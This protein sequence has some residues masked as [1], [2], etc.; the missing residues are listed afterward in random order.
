MRKTVL[1]IGGLGYLGGRIA[2]SLLTINK[3]KVILGTRGNQAGLSRKLAGC[4]IA[5][6]NLLE[7]N[8]IQK[9]LKGVDIIIHLAA[10]NANEC[11][12]NPSNA[13]LVNAL[14]TLNLIQSAK[15]SNVKRIIYFSTAH[16]YGSYLSGDISEESLP[17]PNS[18]YAITHHVAENY[19]IKLGKESDISTTVVRLSNAIGSP[20]SK[21]SNCW[22]L[23]ANDIARQIVET[24]K[25]SLKS[26]GSQLRD[27]IP[28]SN[29]ISAVMLLLE[30]HYSG[31]RVFNLGS[32]VSLSILD[33][34]KLLS[35]RAK[36]ILDVDVSVTTGIDK[37]GPND[38]FS[39]KIN[40]IT[41][42]GYSPTS[43]LEDEIDNLLMYV[44]KE[45]KTK[46]VYE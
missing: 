19:I 2:Q 32:G 17:K 23:V 8:S 42:L 31:G 14:G 22:T 21:D 7:K 11:A 1:I 16:V 37:I 29:I 33:L 24:N 20:A 25:V 41:S 45:F 36:A 6:M 9:T 30:S 35:A 39:Y 27:F 10:M 46:D 3:Y 26:S 44:N 4:D 28:I 5:L 12:E 15:N 38:H 13:L 18:H 34:A 43:S 40:K